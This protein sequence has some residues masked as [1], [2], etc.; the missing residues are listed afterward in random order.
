[1]TPLRGLEANRENARRSN[2]FPCLNLVRSGTLGAG[3]RSRIR[4]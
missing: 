1:M 2:A 3:K 4:K